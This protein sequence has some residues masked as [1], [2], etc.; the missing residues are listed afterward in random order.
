L[1]N[2]STVCAAVASPLAALP[3]L[4]LF[5]LAR[6]ETLLSQ[7]RKSLLVQLFQP[8]KFGHPLIEGK[9]AKAVRIH[10]SIEPIGRLSAREIEVSISLFKPRA[11]APFR[12]L[13]IDG[14]DGEPHVRSA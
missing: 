3:R 14:L 1:R 8:V 11:R 12:K 13:F 2:Q 6:A 5:A 9:A 7:Q 4:I 10:C